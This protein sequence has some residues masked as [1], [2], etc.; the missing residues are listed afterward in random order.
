MKV[1]SGKPKQLPTQ[2]QNIAIT[3]R[4]H[5]TLWLQEIACEFRTGGILQMVDFVVA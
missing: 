1:A 5:F 4:E 2:V 3:T